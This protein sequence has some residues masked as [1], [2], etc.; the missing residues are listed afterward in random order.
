MKTDVKKLDAYRARQGKLRVVEVPPMQYL[1]VD[2]EGDPNT[3]TAYS[4]ALATLYPVA[5]TLKFASKQLGRDYVVPPLEA[6]WWAPD[7]AAFTSARDTSRWHWTVMIMTPCWVTAGMY[8]DAVARVASRQRPA[9]L[10]LVRL[11][12]LDEGRCVQTLHVGPYDAEAEVLA[13]MHDEFIPAA[14]LRMT[15][16][17]HEIYL[18]DPRRVEPARLRTILRQPVEAQREEST[19]PP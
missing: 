6:L 3:A 19:Q 18:S 11:D 12:R 16:R 4:D 9:S 8:D 2:G 10:G 13:R 14:G 5:Y 15:G 7:M 1:M 17:H